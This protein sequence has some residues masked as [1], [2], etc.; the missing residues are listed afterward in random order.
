MVYG[1][2]KIR[3]M[4]STKRK[5]ENAPEIFDRLRLSLESIRYNFPVIGFSWD[6]RY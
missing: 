3:P 4:K 1:Q 2:P 5:F 6:S